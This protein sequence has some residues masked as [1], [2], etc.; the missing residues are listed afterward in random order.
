M[1]LVS[2]VAFENFKWLLMTPAVICNNCTLVLQNNTAE[3]TH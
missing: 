2:L 3:V 1:N